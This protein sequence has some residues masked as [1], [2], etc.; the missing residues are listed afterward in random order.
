MRASGFPNFD[1]KHRFESIISPQDA[2]ASVLDHPDTVVPDAAIL[3]YGRTMARHA[4]EAWGARAID[5]YPGRWYRLM[6]IERG[7]VEV[8]VVGDFG[9]GAPVAAMVLEELAALG[10][11]R[12]LS[13][14]VA[15]GLRADAAFGQLVLCT[16][17]LRDE[18]VSHHY[19]PAARLA[20]PSE[21]LTEALGAALSARGALYSRGP[22]WT[23]D[24]PFR[25]TL[26]E[27][28]AYQ[29]EGLLTVEMEAAAL[30]AVGR[31]R[32][33]DVASAFVVSDTLLAGDRWAFDFAA[34]AVQEGRRTLIDAAIATFVD[35]HIP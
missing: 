19:V 1:G 8:G 24:A 16:A 34:E 11:R 18:G 20:Y 21:R 27:A 15:G 28:R 33:V 35:G 12:F 25:E 32:G 29:A 26:E 3:T 4:V 2:V 30:F 13:V 14:G 5:D 22:T 9:I 23:I 10:V 7:G 31:Y 6:L 17:A